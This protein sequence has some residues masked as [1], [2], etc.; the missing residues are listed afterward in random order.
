M[1]KTS[2]LKII[3]AY[4]S[5]CLIFSMLV[6]NNI[7][8]IKK[9]KLVETLWKFSRLPETHC[10]FE[11]IG[12][13]V[14]LDSVCSEDIENSLCQLFTFGGISSISPANSVIIIHLS[15]KDV[16]DQINYCRKEYGEKYIQAAEIVAQKVGEVCK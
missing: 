1:L 13:R 5:I 7:S 10:L 3:S 12:F 2:D 14:Y 9:E 11:D 16:E 15:S 8:I 6:K 4:Q